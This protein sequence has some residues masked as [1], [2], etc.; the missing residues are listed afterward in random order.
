MHLFITRPIFLL[1]ITFTVS[2]CS[3]ER[4]Q[5]FSMGMNMDLQNVRQFCIAA[6]LKEETM[7]FSQCVIELGK[8][9]LSR[10]KEN[11]KNTHNGYESS[12]SMSCTFIGNTMECL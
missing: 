3:A 7:E 10:P 11:C 6:G 2:A 1:L 12:K 9:Q 5:K 8:A 4:M